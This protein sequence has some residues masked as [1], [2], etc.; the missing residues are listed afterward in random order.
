MK[1]WQFIMLALLVLGATT[2]NCWLLTSMREPEK[3]QVVAVENASKLPS[4]DWPLLPPRGSKR[5]LL[6]EAEFNKAL[7]EVQKGDMEYMFGL[8][9]WYSRHGHAELADQWLIRLEDERKANGLPSYIDTIPP[10][11][12]GNTP[13]P[14]LTKPVGVQ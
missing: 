2:L 7:I 5:L 9:D 12:H 1:F 4:S 8:I 14:T 11:M 13:V 10:I 6:D 3:P